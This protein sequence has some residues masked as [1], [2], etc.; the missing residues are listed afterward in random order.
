[1]D[2]LGP[3]TVEQVLA[4]AIRY[5][6][7]ER[8]HWSGQRL[9]DEVTKLGGSLYRHAISKI[10]VGKRGVTI[11]EL[12]YLARAMKMSPSLL[13]FPE[14]TVTESIPDQVEVG[15]KV[16]QMTAAAKWFAAEDSFEAT[17]EKEWVLPTWLR[18]RNDAAIVAHINAAADRLFTSEDPNPEQLQKRYEETLFRVREV[19]A[20][21]VR[22]GFKPPPPP[23]GLEYVDNVRHVALSP[24]EAERILRENPGA[25]RE[26]DVRRPNA[27]RVMKQGDPTR[28]K[29]ALERGVEFTEQFYR[30]HPEGIA[31]DQDEDKP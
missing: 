29:E 21:I 10:E 12:M 4:R 22:H 11:D 24:D 16:M 8:L 9:A 5:H 2:E 20:E 31:P 27:G 15:G 28:L 7:E 3:L 25:L 23:K 6:R 13:L 30:E 14:L 19:R 26:V 1:M 17:E 18:R